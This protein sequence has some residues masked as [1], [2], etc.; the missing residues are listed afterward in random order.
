MEACGGKKADDFA[1]G[2]QY[3][4]QDKYREDV[5]GRE[6]WKMKVESWLRE[7]DV[8]VLMS[9]AVTSNRHRQINVA[10]GGCCPSPRH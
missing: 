10:G 7:A 9:A 6:V 1:I 3:K 8:P 5:K 2:Y 4:I